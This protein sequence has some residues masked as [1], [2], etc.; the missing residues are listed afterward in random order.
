MGLIYTIFIAG[1]TKSVLQLVEK[2][3]TIQAS[4]GSK[5]SVATFGGCLLKCC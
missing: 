4:L 3:Y 1:R 5:V 2:N